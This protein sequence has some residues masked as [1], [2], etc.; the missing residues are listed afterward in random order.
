VGPGKQR[1]S[2]YGR[3]PR[4]I[5]VADAMTTALLAEMLAQ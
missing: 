2:S 3:A 4:A 5:L 1:Q